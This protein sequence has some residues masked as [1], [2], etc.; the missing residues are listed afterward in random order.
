MP[1]E[2]EILSPYSEL[3]RLHNEGVAFVIHRLG[4]REPYKFTQDDVI[5]YT[6]QYM[7]FLDCCDVNIKDIQQKGFILSKIKYIHFI[8]FLTNLQTQL[9]SKS[10]SEYLKESEINPELMTLV[11]MVFSEA[12]DVEQ[13]EPTMDSYHYEVTKKMLNYLEKK[14]SESNGN[15]NAKRIIG[16]LSSV[17]KASID[18]GLSV[19]TNSNTLSKYEFVNSLAMGY[20]EKEQ[21]VNKKFKWPWK[22]DAEGAVGGLIRGGIVGTLGGLAGAAIGGLLG[23]VGGS[24]SNSIIKSIPAFNK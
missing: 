10:I 9:N 21:T 1:N 11:D 13:V 8:E 18:H 14:N 5:R 23:A 7:F 16:V 20:D 6:A 15:E 19:I 3:G 12:N 22:A 17:S 4:V 24:I 2:N